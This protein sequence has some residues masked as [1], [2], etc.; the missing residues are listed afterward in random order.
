MAKEEAGEDCMKHEERKGYTEL[1][2]HA[3]KILYTCKVNSV[4]KLRKQ[5][6]AVTLWETVEYLQLI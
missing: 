2:K 6:L 4:K 1:L 5:P 3:L